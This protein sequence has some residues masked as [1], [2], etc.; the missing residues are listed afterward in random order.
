MKVSVVMLT[1]SH[2]KYI[3][4]SIHGVLMQD[5]TFDFDLIIANDCSLDKTDSIIK[6][7]LINHPN[8]NKIKYLMHNKNIGMMSNFVSALKITDGQ[9]I[10]LCDGD[11]YWTDPFKLQKQVD[12]LDKNIEFSICFTDFKVL[13]ENTKSF[14]SQNLID[15]YKNK[16]VFNQR[17]IILSNFIPTLTLMFRNNKEVFNQLE[18][19]LYP[20]DWFLN[21][22]NSEHG[23]IKFL[24]FES[25]VYRIH[26]GGVC[27]ASNPID[28]NI[29]YLNSIKIFRKVY[30]K[31]YLVQ[32]YFNLL[33]F[34]IRLQNI[35]FKLL[36]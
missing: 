11:D 29:K 10:A 24:P 14:T 22:L 5:C 34:K 20:L 31:N 25:A 35:K 1:Y 28:N 26:D 27:S 30:S 6:D 2:D 32:Y 16:S 36:K 19:N 15:K 21:I 23:K 12:F 7:I 3:E 13:N 17:N 9:Y 8:A 4:K 18:L 33:I